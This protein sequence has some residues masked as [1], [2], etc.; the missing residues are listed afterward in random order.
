MST[1]RMCDST[2][3]INDPTGLEP[4]RRIFSEASDGWTTGS[5]NMNTRNPRTGR[6]ETK[7]VDQ[8]KCPH[9]TRA[10]L[11]LPSQSET[12]LAAARQ[13]Y[14][15]LLEKETQIGKYAITNGDIQ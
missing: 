4:W 2:P 15:E 11:N 5:F 7:E 13:A 3:C 6:M 8:D 12:D 1:T 10:M 9:C 14:I